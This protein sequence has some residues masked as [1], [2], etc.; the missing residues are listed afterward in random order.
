M[1][2]LFKIGIVCEHRPNV[3]YVIR[4]EID[5][6]HQTTAPVE[7]P[8]VDGKTATNT[9]DHKFYNRIAVQN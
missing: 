3:K 5:N 8:T 1:N 6:N 4:A 9:T 7:E 2:Q